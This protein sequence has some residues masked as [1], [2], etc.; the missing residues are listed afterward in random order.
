MISYLTHLTFYLPSNYLLT[1]K[2]SPYLSK[3]YQYHL[4]IFLGH[5]INR[6]HSLFFCFFCSCWTRFIRGCYEVCKEDS[7][8]FCRSSLLRICCYIIEGYHRVFFQPL[9][10]FPSVRFRIVQLFLSF[11]QF[12]IHI[13][14]RET[15]L[16]YC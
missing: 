7:F 2:Y 9:L 5:V 10:M 14:Q 3:E 8:E 11:V 15:E 12:I 13:L 1:L 16:F 4:F 6:A